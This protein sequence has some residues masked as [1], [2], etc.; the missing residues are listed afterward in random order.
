MSILTFP[1]DDVGACSG[2]EPYDRCFTIKDKY[3][4]YIASRPATTRK[5]KGFKVHHKMMTTE[6]W[7]AL[8]EFWRKVGDHD[9]FYWEFPIALYGVAGYGGDN[10]GEEDFGG[11]DTEGDGMGFGAGPV[12]L[13]QFETDILYQKHIKPFYWGVSYV[14]VEV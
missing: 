5:V 12:F 6:Q 11:W 8:V 2:I 14:V 10:L 4:G 7:L 1:W 3:I 9:A 13:V